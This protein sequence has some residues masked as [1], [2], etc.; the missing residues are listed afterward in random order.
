M[1]VIPRVDLDT[2]SFGTPLYLWLLVVPGVLFVLWALQVA[3]RRADANRLFRSRIVPVR[4]RFSLAGDLAFWLGVLV[5][6]AL[7]IVALAAPR[8][9]VAA[10]RTSSADIVILLDGSASMYVKDVSPDR[11]RRSV[12]FLRT[13]AE[14]LSWRGDRVALAL[15]AHLSAPQVRLTKDPNA[16]FFFLDH[17][18]EQSPFRLEDA[19]TWDTNI[20]EG[21]RWGLRIVEKDEELFGPSGNPRA[22]VV[23]T[24]G[25]AWSGSVNNSLQQARTREIP[26]FVVGIGTTG[27]GI[28]PQPTGPGAVP[29][30]RIRSV[31]DRASLIRIAQQGGGEYFEIGQGSDQD[32]AFGIIDR[33]RRR[34]IRARLIETHEELYWR[35]LLAAGIV[36][37]AGTLLLRGRTEL[38]WQGAGALGAVLLL[39]AAW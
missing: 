28:I 34:D 25:Q 39:L 16:L 36:L 5:A 19:P 21:I 15:F 20:E 10:V 12:R 11:W 22:F 37:C 8:A 3:R 6:A 38:A 27:G 30:E 18:G 24:D 23:V 13:F 26:V 33:L 17:L 14:A 2:V 29:V 35:F 31:L 1:T 32:V 4:Q 7:C 9:R